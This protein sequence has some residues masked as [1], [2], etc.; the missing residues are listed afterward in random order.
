M[1]REDIYKKLEYYLSRCIRI[2][3][4]CS[5]NIFYN[6]V[7]IDLKIEEDFFVFLDDRLGEIPVLFDEIERIEPF[8]EASN[9]DV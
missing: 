3:L 4:T 5:N 9:N 7:V 1:A 8:R 2:H 6:G